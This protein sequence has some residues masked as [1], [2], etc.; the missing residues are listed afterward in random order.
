MKFLKEM[1]GHYMKSNT[2]EKGAALS[3]YVAF[4]FLPMIV[5]VISVLGL[6]FREDTVSEEL[7]TQLG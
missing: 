1:F 4:S 5:I 3:Y 7:I 6:I 2:F